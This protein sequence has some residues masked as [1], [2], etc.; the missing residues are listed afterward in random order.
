MS[1]LETL[2]QMLVILLLMAVGFAAYKRK[3]VSD[4]SLKDMSALTANIFNPAICFS[5]MVVNTGGERPGFEGGIFIVGSI[6][7][8][9]CILIGWVFSRILSKDRTARAVYHMMFIFSNLGFI[10]IPV[11]SS[12]FGKQYIFYVAIYM[13]LYNV[14]FYTLGIHILD[15]ITP[16]AGESA[17]GVDV[18]ATAGG[19]TAAGGSNAA[20]GESTKKSWLSRVKPLVNM[21]TISCLAAI[22]VFVT[23]VKV[24]QILGST[25]TY[26]GEAA[27]PVSLVIIGANVAQQPDLRAIFTDLKSYQFLL[28]KM[29]VLPTLVIFLLKFMPMPEEVRQ[30]SMILMAMPVG[31][32]NLIMLTERGVASR[33]CSNGI[34]LTSIASVVT[35]PVMAAVYHLIMG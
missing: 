33:E 8:A 12:L 21:G 6:V 3:L 7:F 17:S 35:L 30:I 31:T 14:L 34:I 10:G 15:G 1:P 29:F 4:R 23:G 25:I 13:F 22:V 24:P 32:M 27:V 19:R 2:K 16:G 28:L 5:S 20:A 26:L 9:A 18:S 11:V